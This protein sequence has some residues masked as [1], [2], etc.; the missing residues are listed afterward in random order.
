MSPTLPF[1]LAAAVVLSAPFW[2]RRLFYAW[3]A[4][5][6][7]AF[8]GEVLGSSS[9]APDRRIV[10]SLS[11]LPDRIKNLGPTLQ[12]LLDQT[13]PPDEIILA[14]PDISLRQQKPYAIPGFL[15]KMPRIRIVRCGRDWGPAT[16]F[17][18]VVQEEL[19][20]GRA[21]T[22]IVV[23][24]DD[25]IYPRDAIETY[26]HYSAETPDAALCFRGARM[27]PNFDWRD[28]IMIHGNRLREPKRVAV[29]TGCGSYLVKPR[30]FD[31]SLWNY[32]TAPRAAFYMD[33]IWIS[34][35]LDR[36]GIKKFVVPSSR[37]LLTAKQ[38]SGTMTLHDVP[39][40]RQPNNNETIAFFG[41]GWNVFQRS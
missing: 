41:E 36:S 20:H 35:C 34:G 28:S 31:E 11:T 24:D 39:N 17:I 32:S 9:A 5:R 18:P 27:P 12:C 30:F 23:V 38:Q 10:V 6:Q 15:E 21:N 14:L 13:R 2:G 37:R 26:L 33:D 29:M 40:G 8:I 1:L 19:K 16:K 4:R 25:R 22:L 7:Q 3:L